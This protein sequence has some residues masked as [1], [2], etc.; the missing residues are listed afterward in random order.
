MEAA[1]V[2]TDKRPRAAAATF[3][4]GGVHTSKGFAEFFHSF[5]WVFTIE[6]LKPSC[7]SVGEVWIV[8]FRLGLF[9]RF[10]G[11]SHPV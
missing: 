6:R 1:L 7:V 8:K 3:D 11:G 2:F 10:P 9:R 4:L 5:K